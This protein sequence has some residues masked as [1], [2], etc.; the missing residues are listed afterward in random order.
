MKISIDNIIN[1][2]KT[3][4]N[5]IIT[6]KQVK[7]IKEMLDSGRKTRSQTSIKLRDTKI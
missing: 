5:I 2:M 1:F 6:D 3:Q 7:E 4:Q